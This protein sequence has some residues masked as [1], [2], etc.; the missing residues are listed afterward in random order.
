MGGLS[1]RTAV[2]AWLTLGATLIAGGS[3]SASATPEFEVWDTA[4]MFP[5][6]ANPSDVVTYL[7]HLAAVGFDGAWIT[8]PPFYWAGGV[9]RPNFA[10]ET[11]GRGDPAL[12]FPPAFLDPNPTYM[13]RIEF[14]IDQAASRGLRIGLV[15][16][17][18]ADFA[19]SRPGIGDHEAPPWDDWLDH[20]GLPGDGDPSYP[21][22]G[23][24]PYRYGK[25]LAER[26]KNRTN[27]VWV[28]GGDYMNGSDEHITRPTWSHLVRGLR[29]H[30]ANQDATYLTGGYESSW[31]NFAGEWWQDF[32]SPHLGHC[33]N[34]EQVESFIRD[35]VAAYPNKRIISSESRYEDELAG[36]CTSPPH[37]WEGV[38]G[39]QE[40]EA[41]ARA[42]LDGGGHGV[43]FG[44]N[45]RWNWNGEF[46]NPT[47]PLQSLGSL[48]EQLVL[49]VAAGV[50]SPPDPDHL[51]LVDPGGRW[52]LRS[53]DG[54][55]HAFHYGV[56]GDIPLLGDW[57]GDGL[58]TPGMYRPANGSA[59]LTNQLPPNGG[60]GVADP[61]LTFSFGVRGDQ[62]FVGDW[63]GDGVDTLGIR[64]GGKVYLTNSN[65]TGVAQM[66]FWFGAPRDVAFGGDPDGDGRDSVFL[67][68]PASGFTYFTHST[69]TGPNAIAA[70][71][72]Q[73]TFG[74]P[75][76]RFV[77][78]DWDGDGDDTVGVFRPS[79][80][81]VYLRN[82]NT[83][84][85]A[86]ESYVFGGS[87]WQP[88]AGRWD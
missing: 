71:H 67:Y 29:D 79:N 5:H 62:V 20:A 4:W 2:I 83:T 84:G 43:V 26:W 88:V 17:W 47:P 51:A 28:M 12:G 36:W 81:T 61:S 22:T 18:G 39:P 14:V 48:G 58:D 31:Y 23:S 74:V 11:F 8:V 56:P 45:S 46:P 38:P 73:L 44:H 35:L 42:V 33:N 24:K 7:D 37:G 80:T 57:N 21:D 52:Y 16:A 85:P 78:G 1:L 41:D 27:V 63:D 69:P 19:G 49:A 70:T 68:R 86:D 66:E 10:G 50:G 25:L 9:A 60:V 54:S 76:D 87:S 13:D 77:I 32:L 6:K 65:S 34:A 72:G 40:V 55:V 15:V 59:Y 53:P 30:G 64:R 3:S 75:T 82:S